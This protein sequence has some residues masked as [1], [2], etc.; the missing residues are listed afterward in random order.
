MKKN[1][2]LVGARGLEPPLP[3]T[4]NYQT[5]SRS[6]LRIFAP[7]SPAYLHRRAG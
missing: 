6:R 3:L 4:L 2:V 1:A 5:I 7:V